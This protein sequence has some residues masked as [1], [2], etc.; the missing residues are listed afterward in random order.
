MA[1]VVLNTLG[2]GSVLASCAYSAGKSVAMD[3]V[4]TKTK[5]IDRDLDIKSITINAGLSG[6]NGIINRI[7]VNEYASSVAAKILAGKTSSDNLGS[8]FVDFVV[9]EIISKE[10]VKLPAY[11]VEE[12]T[13][14]VVKKL[15][16]IKKAQSNGKTLTPEEI[17]TYLKDLSNNFTKTQQQTK[18]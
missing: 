3:I 14:A 18:A 11:T 2:P 5:K 10:G 12:I 17:N 8:K 15:E 1:N 6:V 13:S 9:K 16:E 7:I 4:N